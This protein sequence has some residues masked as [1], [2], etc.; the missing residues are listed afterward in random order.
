MREADERLTGSITGAVHVPR[1]VLELRADPTSPRHDARLDPG[2]RVLPHCDDGSKSALVADTLRGMGYPT[3]R[4][5]PAASPR[6]AT[7][8][9]RW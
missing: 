9:C 3:W 6:G 7:P 5:S 1:G 4:T 2:R 8:L